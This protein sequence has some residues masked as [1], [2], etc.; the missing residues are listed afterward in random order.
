MNPRLRQSDRVRNWRASAIAAQAALFTSG[1]GEILVQEL[2]L[3]GQRQNV[4]CHELTLAGTAVVIMAL[5][6]QQNGPKLPLPKHKKTTELVNG[7]KYSKRAKLKM[8]FRRL[9]LGGMNRI[10]VYTVPEL[11]HHKIPYM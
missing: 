2:Y 10:S 6:S 7:K 1:F 9:R 11:K 3:T 8:F 5:E 4:L